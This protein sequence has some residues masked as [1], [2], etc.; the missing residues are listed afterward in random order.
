MGLCLSKADGVTAADSLI[1]GGHSRLTSAD[2]MYINRLLNTLHNNEVEMLSQIFSYHCRQS[3]QN[4][5]YK[6]YNV[7]INDVNTLISLFPT[8][9]SDIFHEKML[10]SIFQA[11][12]HSNKSYVDLRDFSRI[13]VIAT[14]G[15]FD[16]M[17]QLIFNIF[18]EVNERGIDPGDVEKIVMETSIVGRKPTNVRQTHP[19]TPQPPPTSAPGNCP[20]I[21][22]RIIIKLNMLSSGGCG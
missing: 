1:V 20:S 17:I 21:N 9:R 15:S 7:V 16:D 5:T 8:L 11:F 4:E 14:R 6:T 10:K 19:S 3:N 22:S 13:H 12:D 2:A 18:A